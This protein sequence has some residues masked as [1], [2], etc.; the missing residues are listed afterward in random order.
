LRKYLVSDLFLFFFFLFPAIELTSVRNAA[1]R[2][3]VC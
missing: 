2:S 3:A 1:V